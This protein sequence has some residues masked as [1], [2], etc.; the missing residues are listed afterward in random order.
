M[1]LIQVKNQIHRFLAELLWAIGE[2]Q[3]HDLGDEL[4]QRLLKTDC[5]VWKDIYNAALSDE[6]RRLA[7]NP[8]PKFVS[9]A[10]TGLILNRWPLPWS[11]CQYGNAVARN[12]SLSGSMRRATPCVSSSTAYGKR[13]CRR[14]LRD[15]LCS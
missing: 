7:D 4:W 6:R 1:R 14:R 12:E 13:F 5:A 11:E 3:T 9:R 8:V 2:E 15:L 10:S